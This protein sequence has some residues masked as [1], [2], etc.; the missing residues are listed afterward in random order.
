VARSIAFLPPSQGP[1]ADRLHGSPFPEE[2]HISRTRTRVN[3]DIRISPIRLVDADG[4]QVGIVPLEKAREQA[5]QAELDLVEVAPRARPPVVRIMDWGKY[6]YEQQKAAK[7]ARK[8]QHT[9]DVKELKFR[10]KTD[11]HDLD[12][13]VRNARRFLRKGKHVRI[14]VRFRA[15]EMRRPENGQ[16]VLDQV[17]ERLE[18]VASVSNRDTGLQGRVMQMLLEPAGQADS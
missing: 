4:Q 18:D 2:D 6:Q 12:F 8:K 14:T 10:P 13:K 7:E 3:D 16:R 15:R 11:D 5:A 17:A 1:E 9:Y